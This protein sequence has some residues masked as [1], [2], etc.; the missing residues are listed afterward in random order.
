MSHLIIPCRASTCSFILWVSD[1]PGSC[2]RSLGSCTPG[3]RLHTCFMFPGLKEVCLQSPDGR[4]QAG[5]CSSFWNSPS[6][7]GA[8][9]PAG[10]ATILHWLRFCHFFQTQSMIH[11]PD[12]SLT[13]GISETRELR[14]C[15]ASERS[16]PYLGGSLQQKRVNRHTFFP[17]EALSSS[18]GSGDDSERCHASRALSVSCSDLLSLTTL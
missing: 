18:G 11:D 10:W 7:A 9:V 5:K 1:T 12:P 3:K 8:H 4:A 17:H 15:L 14:Y 16:E 2:L 6:W 13:S